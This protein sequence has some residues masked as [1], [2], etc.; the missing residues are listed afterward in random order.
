MKMHSLLA[1]FLIAPQAL[2]TSFFIRPFSEFTKTTEVIV[3]GITTDIH[4][5][6]GSNENG[7]KTIYTYANLSLKDVIKGNLSGSSIRIRK[8]G[9][10]VDDVTLEIPSSVEFKEGEEGVFFLGDEQADHS[11]EVIGMEL[12]KF[13]L[14]NQD[15]NEVLKGPLFVYSRP[16]S[17]NHAEHPHANTLIRDDISENLKPWS[18]QQLKDL[19]KSQGDEPQ[20]PKNGSSAPM[21]SPG[22]NPKKVNISNNLSENT[23]Q[24]AVENSTTENDAT[25]QESLYI[26]SRFWYVLALATLMLGVY[27]FKRRG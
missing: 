10:T 5:E 11:Y 24:N 9:G 27:L 8:A 17:K 2:A 18:I 12:G 6:S 16:P 19:V 1:L 20:S 4:A 15:G 14:V 21:P 7:E 3:R 13:N 22:E 23:P 25:Q 26:D